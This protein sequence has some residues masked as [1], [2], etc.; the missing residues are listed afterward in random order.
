MKN[1]LCYNSFQKK[2]G[3]STCNNHIT[4][5]A[6]Y[7]RNGWHMPVLHSFIVKKESVADGTSSAI[8]SINKGNAA[9]AT[10][11]SAY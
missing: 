7:V 1:T 10:T 3:G 9:L 11:D 8:N 6:L 4:I 2:D 5:P